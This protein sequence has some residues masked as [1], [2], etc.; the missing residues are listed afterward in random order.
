M[1]QIFPSKYILSDNFR[2]HNYFW[3]ARES[4]HRQMLETA[5][6]TNDAREWHTDK[7]AWAESKLRNGY[8]L[9]AK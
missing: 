3:K 7:L 9:D 1:R 8:V 2:I 6:L 5:K 4:Y